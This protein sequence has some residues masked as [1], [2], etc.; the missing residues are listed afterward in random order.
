MWTSIS[1]PREHGMSEVVSR[2]EAEGATVL[3]R[4]E[5]ECGKDCSLSPKI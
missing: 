3:I 1:S 5:R 2:G 4:V